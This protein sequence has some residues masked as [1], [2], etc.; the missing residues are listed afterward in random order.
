[1]RCSAAA[2]SSMT[3]RKAM[4]ISCGEL[5]AL[6]K[7]VYC[8]PG[9]HDDPAR[10]RQALARPPFQVGGLVDLGAWRLDSAG[11]LRARTGRRSCRADEAAGLARGADRQRAPRDGLR[12]SPSGVAW[13]A[14]GST[15]SAS[16]MP[17]SSSRYSMRTTGARRS[18]GVTCTSASTSG[19]AACGCSP[20][21]RPARSSC[22][23]RT[24]SRST[25]GRPPIVA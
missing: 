14:A 15:R 21:L 6:G 25:P 22:R 1:M 18:P 10:L 16:T 20:R 17:M 11:Q 5:G 4:H 13:R 23:C 9:N 24:T 7:P 3:S 8:I 19:V 12:P 2:I